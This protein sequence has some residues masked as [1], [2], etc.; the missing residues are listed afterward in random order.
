M[1]FIIINASILSRNSIQFQNLQF[2]YDQ[3]TPFWIWWIWGWNIPFQNVYP[4]FFQNIGY[5][6]L[7]S[8]I[9]QLLTKKSH[10]MTIGQA[11]YVQNELDSH[12]RRLLLRQQ[13]GKW[14]K[15]TE[16]DLKVYLYRLTGIFP[17]GRWLNIDHLLRKLT[18]LWTF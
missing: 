5:L 15:R 2:S 11:L 8:L 7:N 18:S 16:N 4:I 3:W 6:E 9:K 17:I 13:N 10:R 12:N 1:K 14:L